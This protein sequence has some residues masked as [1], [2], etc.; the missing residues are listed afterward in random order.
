MMP[1]LEARGIPCETIEAFAEWGE[2]MWPEGD[3]RGAM[4][5]RCSKTYVFRA[6]GIAGT[7]RVA[8][9]VGGVRVK[10]FT[11]AEDFARYPYTGPETGT[12]R[13]RF[14][15][16]EGAR[17][18]VQVDW[19]EVDGAR[20][21]AEHQPVNTGAFQKGACGGGD[22]YSEWLHCEGYIQFAPGQTTA[23]FAPGDLDPAETFVELHPNPARDFAVV[24]FAVAE[25]FAPASGGATAEV[26]V[27]TLFGQELLRERH[28]VHVGDN[29]VELALGELPPATYTVL[30][31]GAGAVR[32]G[33]LV[34]QE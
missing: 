2:R 31:Y 33:I 7:E 18:D 17:H 3:W 21:Q 11:L 20:M 28:A 12:V 32:K 30:V 24:R 26:V 5:A 15:R 14:L 9:V 19:L 27:G 13:I 25:R 1:R 34:V 8:L 4:S 22:G 23:R 10:T 6:R 29:R 16:D